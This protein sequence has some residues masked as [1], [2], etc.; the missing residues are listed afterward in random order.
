MS[1]ALHH[2]NEPT[3]NGVRDEVAAVE[4]KSLR[5]WTPTQAV[6]A[7]SAHPGLVQARVFL[8]FAA[9]LVLMLPLVKLVPDHHG[10]W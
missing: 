1:P 4:P 3:S 2:A 5:T 6:I 10:T 9:L 7:R 8:V